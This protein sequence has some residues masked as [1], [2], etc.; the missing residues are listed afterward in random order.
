MESSQKYVRKRLILFAHRMK[1]YCQEYRRTFRTFRVTRNFFSTCHQMGKENQQSSRTTTKES[2]VWNG[3]LSIVL[4][5]RM[6][7]LIS[8]ITNAPLPVMNLWAWSSPKTYRTW[9]ADFWF[10]T[11]HGPLHFLHTGDR[12]NSHTVD[13][14]Y[15]ELSCFEAS[16][17]MQKQTIT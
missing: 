13:F 9:C 11:A 12:K 6:F 4:K 5:L 15:N 10:N 16:I 3:W 17:A 14:R 8:R 1:Y 2:H 7:P